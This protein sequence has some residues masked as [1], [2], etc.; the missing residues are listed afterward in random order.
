MGHSIHNVDISK[1]LAH[2]T[3]VGRTAKFS[4]ATLES[5]YG[6]ETNLKL[7]GKALVNIPAVSMPSKLETSVALCGVTKRHISEWPFIVP[8]TRLTCVMIMLFN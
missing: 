2:M 8:G 6:R 4:K 3:P 5:A 7:T 1:L